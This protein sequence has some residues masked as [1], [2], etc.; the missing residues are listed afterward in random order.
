MNVIVTGSHGLIG[1]EL[2][3]QLLSGG[4]QVTRLVRHGRSGPGE[5]SWDPPAGTIDGAALEGHDAIVH[6]AGVGIGDHRWTDEHKA[7][8]LDSRLQ[9]TR[10]LTT[11]LAG[12]RQPPAVVASGSA[13]G[14]YGDRGDE[15]LTEASEPGSGFL[16]DVVRQWE[17]AAAPAVEAGIRVAYLRSG[18][19]QSSRGGA[20]KKQLPAFKAGLGGRLGSGRQW[21]A[22]IAIDDEVNAIR[23]VLDNAAIVGPVNLCAPTPVTNGEFT[24][25]LGKVLH[26]PTALP[27]PTPALQ[28]LFGREM[29][30]EMLLG[31][32][33][34]LPRVLESTGYAF[35][36]RTL[37]SALAA[38]LGGERA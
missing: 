1:G 6:L 11:T 30:A 19:V 32:Q 21:L 9:G 38:I 26:R 4:H 22:W 2:V 15:E 28:L 20:L 5:A 7:A 35:A 36:H 37:P 14:Y 31:G 29:V 18:V 12:L 13:V 16:A 17:A 10:L 8:V 25:T 24:R 3:S 33:R 34:V 27:T 23:H